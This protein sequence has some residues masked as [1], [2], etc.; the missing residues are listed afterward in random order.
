M[1][2]SKYTADSKAE[3]EVLEVLSLLPDPGGELFPQ[4]LFDQFTSFPKLPAEVRDDIWHLA[5]LHKRTI[6]FDTWAWTNNVTKVPSSALL[7][8]SLESRLVALKHLK[9]ISF[10]SYA[11]KFHFNPAFDTFTFPS[12]EQILTH[13]RLCEAS[14][15]DIGNI[16]S[17]KIKDVT[18]L[19]VDRYHISD[20]LKPLHL[21]EFCG[22]PPVQQASKGY[23]IGSSIYNTGLMTANKITPLMHCVLSIGCDGCS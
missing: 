22:I 15:R 18:W 13:G 21:M 1:P 17:L 12:H 14:Y 6:K 2:A 5:L 9:T 19:E 20:P 10:Y 16:Q 23:P 11:Q 8:V 7:K 3:I 4:T